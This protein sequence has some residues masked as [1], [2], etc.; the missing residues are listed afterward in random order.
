MSE[1]ANDIKQCLRCREVKP[2]GAFSRKN[3]TRNGHC[4]ACVKA[5]QAE[6]HAVHPEKRKEIQHR[7]YLKHHTERV[8]KMAEYRQQNRIELRDGRRDRM[9][10]WKSGKCCKACGE[11]HPACLDFHHRESGNKDFDI[12]YAVNI[13]MGD[14]LIA[15]EI[16]KCDVLCRNCHTKLHWALCNAQV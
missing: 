9:A 11:N 13:G 2:L 5:Y 8:T 10:H 6:Y 14:D 12:S 3:N 4:K 16:A 15:S 7:S 1:M